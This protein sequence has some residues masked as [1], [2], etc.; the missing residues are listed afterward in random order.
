[1]KRG[2][3]GTSGHTEVMD[4]G[5]QRLQDVGRFGQGGFVSGSEHHKA[6]LLRYGS[7]DQLHA[8]PEAVE[9]RLDGRDSSRAS[10]GNEDDGR[11]LGNV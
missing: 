4:V 2:M 10:V 9:T 1:M 8:L 11:A 7:I 5:R 3:R 6:V